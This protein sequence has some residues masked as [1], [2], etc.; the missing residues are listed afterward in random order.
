MVAAEW[1]WVFI[2]LNKATGFVLKLCFT[3]FFKK[4]LPSFV[5]LFDGASDW[6]V[7]ET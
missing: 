6:S 2:S 1:N 4:T 3:G 7:A 5:P